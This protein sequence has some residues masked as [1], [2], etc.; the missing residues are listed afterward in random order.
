MPTPSNR[1]PFP[2]RAE[3]RSALEARVASV[4]MHETLVK[5]DQMALAR[6]RLLALAAEQTM[7]P[8]QTHRTPALRGCLHFPFEVVWSTLGSVFGGSGAYERICL[9]M[10]MS[11]H[12]NLDRYLTYR[13]VGLTA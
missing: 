4:L 2:A 6:Q 5:P 13:L 11:H 1:E 7:L 3:A 10:G 12:Y 8:A 9:P